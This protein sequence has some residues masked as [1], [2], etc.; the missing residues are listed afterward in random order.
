MRDWDRF[1]GIVLAQLNLPQFREFDKCK[2]RNE[3]R[4]LSFCFTI[5]PM[6]QREIELMFFWTDKLNSNNPIKYVYHSI[7]IPFSID[8][9]FTSN[10]KFTSLRAFYT[11]LKLTSFKAGRTFGFL[12][13]ACMGW[14]IQYWN[15][16]E[17]FDNFNLIK[18]L[19]MKTNNLFKNI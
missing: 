1:P 13:T 15:I 2:I 9:N 11:P 7:F 4:V 5:L 10:N 18:I 8:L 12:E 14:K 16:R 6:L 3:Y 17:A 19:P